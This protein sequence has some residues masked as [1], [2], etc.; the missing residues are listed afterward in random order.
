[1]KYACANKKLRCAFDYKSNYFEFKLRV[2]TFVR[3]SALH[4]LNYL[5][6][7]ISFY[8][9]HNCCC[10]TT[11]CIEFLTWQD[12]SY[13]ILKLTIQTWHNQ[14]LRNRFIKKKEQIIVYHL[15][16][17]NSLSKGFGLILCD[18]IKIRYQFIA[19]LEKSEYHRF[20]MTKFVPIA[21]AFYELLFIFCYQSCIHKHHDGK[22]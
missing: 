2:K 1:M 11:D 8:E 19:L 17:N 13:C 10:S 6:F 4:F 18:F 7:M 21:Y 3:F 20:V 5:S 16:A 14:F 15:I 22:Y 12:T 9:E